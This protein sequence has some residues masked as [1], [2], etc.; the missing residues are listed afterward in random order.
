MGEEESATLSSFSKSGE[1]VESLLNSFFDISL[2]LFCLS[3]FDGIIVRANSSW[4]RVLGYPLEEIEGKRFFDF[5]FPEDIPA[6]E[7][8]LGCLLDGEEVRGF[9]NRYQTKSGEIVYFEWN[10]QVKND[11]IYA[12]AR[13]VT[14]NKSLEIEYSKTQ[15]KLVETNRLARIGTW[16]VDLENNTVLWSDMTKEIHEVPHDFVCELEKGID[17]YKEGKDRDRIA[18]VV[19]EGFKNGTPWDEELRIITAK[20]KERWVRAVGVVEMKDGK[21]VRIYGTFHDIDELKR[22][23]ADLREKNRLLELSKE[24]ADLAAEVAAKASRA[25]SHFLANMSHEIRTPMNWIMGTAELLQGTR[26]TRQQTDWVGTIQNSTDHLLTVINDILDFS[27]TESGK[28]KLEAHSFDLR[29]MIYETLEPLKEKLTEK[30]IRLLVQISEELGSMWMGDFSRIRQILINLVGN[31]IK[32]TDEGFILVELKP[33]AEGLLMLAVED[34]GVGIPAE[35]QERIFEAFE[36]ADNS[37]VRSYGGS[38]LGLAICK[39]LAELMGGN[40]KLTSSS[41]R[42]TRMDVSLSISEDLSSG[43]ELALPKTTSELRVMVLD[44]NPMSKASQVYQLRSLGFDVG[45]ADDESRA[46]EVLRESRAKVAL[47]DINME[48]DSQLNFVKSMRSINPDIRV[49]GF[50]YAPKAGDVKRLVKSGFCAYLS[51]PMSPSVVMGVIEMAIEGRKEIITRYSLPSEKSSEEI[52][53]DSSVLKGIHVL[54]AEDNPIN[55]RVV[56]KLLERQG[57]EVSH[58][59][60][61]IETLEKV[62]E[63]I[64]DVIL[65]DVH[66]PEMDG[67]VATRKLREEKEKGLLPHIPIVALTADAM[68]EDRKRCLR[69][70]MDDYLSKPVRTKQLV[71]MILHVMRGD[72]AKVVSEKP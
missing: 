29:K 11:I 22:A 1:E 71:A 66:M 2:D 52:R 47:V 72:E 3:S 35:R 18:Q 67:L 44:P 6:T 32:F 37:S 36:Q 21:P 54:V 55:F 63:R 16:E 24:Q 41:G 38:G 13:D 14:K 33:G 64:P 59:I 27:H 12:V 31:S 40:I 45:E 28:L 30:N 5:I 60:N 46:L 20:G 8:A 25:K 17:F 19:A 48:S 42:G 9:V 53:G 10:A 56:R 4:S 34:S 57:T 62:N 15:E 39:K 65:M 51:L 49:V 70:G 26:L 61:G 50:T 43:M 23:E 58:A 68:E 7:K 69:S